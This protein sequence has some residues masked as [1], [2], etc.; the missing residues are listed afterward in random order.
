[1]ASWVFQ[2]DEKKFQDWVRGPFQRGLSFGVTRYKNRICRGDRVYIWVSGKRA[3]VRALTRATG[4]PGDVEPD[5]ITVG[6]QSHGVWIP[7]E[8]L[9]LLGDPIARSELKSH[10][11]L[12]S[13]QVIRAPQGSNFSLT[14]EEADELERLCL[15]LSRPSFDAVDVYMAELCASAAQAISSA[16][17]LWVSLLPDSGSSD[18]ALPVEKSR[19]L[20]VQGVSRGKLWIGFRKES[21]EASPGV[22]KIVVGATVDTW[23]AAVSESEIMRR[24]EDAWSLTKELVPAMIWSPNGDGRGYTYGGAESIRSWLRGASPTVSLELPVRMLAGKHSIAADISRVLATLLAFASILEDEGPLH[25]AKEPFDVFLSYSRRNLK[26]VERMLTGFRSVTGGSVRIHW[27]EALDGSLSWRAE[28]ESWLRKCDAAIVVLSKA[29]L[30]PDSWV[31]R[32][33][34]KELVRRRD[35]E[36]IPVVG[37]LLEELSEEELEVLEDQGI[38]VVNAERRR[39]GQPVFKTE[40]RRWNVELLRLL[41]SRRV[42]GRGKDSFAMSS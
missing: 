4:N 6:A 35:A 11:I 42:R 8:P 2:C 30:A 40:S 28:I 17:S 34:V 24:A 39:R 13:M 38:L 23:G 15:G 10:P 36:G 1:M 27:D 25:L 5:W 41:Q 26:F 32:N 9:I 22:N 19:L 31:W 20:D 21:P 33:E 12:G 14:D 29:S 37:V 16:S 18:V 7:L 3:G